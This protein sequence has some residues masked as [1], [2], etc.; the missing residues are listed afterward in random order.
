MPNLSDIL[1]KSPKDMTTEELID[2][3]KILRTSRVVGD[4]IVA[5]TTEAR[6]E[7][8]LRNK[9]KKDGKTPEQIDAVI[10]LMEGMRAKSDQEVATKLEPGEIMLPEAD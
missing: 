10:E 9:L 2:K 7:R 4:K 3:L 1:D 5:Q 8:T 6:R